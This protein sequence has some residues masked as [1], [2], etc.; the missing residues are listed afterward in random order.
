[1][2][3]Q[4][5]AIRRVRDRPDSQAHL[6]CARPA[7][8]Y[9]QYVADM[10]RTSTW[11][12]HVTLQVRAPRPRPPGIF[13]RAAPVRRTRH[14]LLQRGW[15]T[16]GGCHVWLWGD[17]PTVCTEVWGTVVAHVAQTL[18]TAVGNEQMLPRVMHFVMPGDLTARW[19]GR[20]VDPASCFCAGCCRRLW[21][22]DLDPHLV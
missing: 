8:D 6:C 20:V 3:W 9:R 7:G 16:I 19:S 22:E 15:S 14:A 2:G 18:Q 4:P 1:M 5:G 17:Q 21:P 11:G 12:D 13:C 10:A